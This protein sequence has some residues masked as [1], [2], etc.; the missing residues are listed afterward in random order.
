MMFWYG[1]D[2]SGWGWV[3]MSVGMVSF[4]ALLVALGV[5]LFRALSGSAEPRATTGPEQRGPVAEQVLAERF[6]RGEIEE[7]EYRRRLTVL[8]SGDGPQPSKR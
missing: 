2:P 4:W 7:D 3:A 8:R 5:L 1:H 6:A